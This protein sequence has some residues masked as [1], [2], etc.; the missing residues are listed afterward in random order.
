MTINPTDQLS[1][2]GPGRTGTAA[3]DIEAAFRQ[4]KRH[5]RRVRLLKIFLPATAAL[6]V[7][8]FVGYSY[9][10]VP[11]G[12]SVN[13]GASSLEGGRI[14]MANPEL[15]GYTQDNRPYSMRASRA[16]QEIGNASMIEME[17]IDARLPV[18]D[19]NW[20]HIDAEKGLLD[21]DANTLRLDAGMTVRMDNGITAH[22]RSAMVDMSAGSLHSSDEVTVEMDGSTISADS[23]SI[24][25]SGKVLV[26]ENRVRMEV[27][28]RR[29]QNPVPN[30]EPADA[31]S[32]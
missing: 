17:K 10:G 29:L 5:S 8:G 2:S 14:V 23:L 20:A 31:Q 32:Q 27:D 9:V 13:L 30:G 7:V 18:D 25:E 16:M 21:R 6:M 4:A 22:F 19:T 11:A 3:R 15:N 12:V 26:F 28:G 1:Q 24:T